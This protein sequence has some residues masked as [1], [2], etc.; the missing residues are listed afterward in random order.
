VRVFVFVER[1]NVQDI[2]SIV[3]AQEKIEG[4]RQAKKI[5]EETI[6][7]ILK[8]IVALQEFIVK[9]CSHPTLSKKTSYTSGGYD[10]Q[11]VTK[12]WYECTICSKV[13]HTKVEYGGF[14]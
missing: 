1:D 7:S 10:Y 12:T 8:E 5:H 4:L 13:L 2:T 3:E 6:S 11:S 14:Q 9:E